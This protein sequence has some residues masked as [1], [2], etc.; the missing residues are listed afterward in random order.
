[1]CLSCLVA[2]RCVTHT[3]T[4]VSGAVCE[5]SAFSEPDNQ[6]IDQHQYISAL[7][8]VSDRSELTMSSYKLIYKVDFN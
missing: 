7:Q 4:Q 2:N 3:E 6:C 8:C 1:M 5:I